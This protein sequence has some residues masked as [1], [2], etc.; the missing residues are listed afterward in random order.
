VKF[1]LKY[2][3]GITKKICMLI[4]SGQRSRFNRLV[5]TGKLDIPFKDNYLNYDLISFSGKR[6]LE[7]QILSISSFVFNVG[8][9]RQWVVYSDGS[10][11]IEERELIQKQFSFAVV[12]E[13]NCNTDLRD[14]K[15]LKD[16][17]ETCHLSKKLYSILGHDYQRQT[18]YADSDIVFYKK[19]FEYFNSEALNK[20][21]WYI[22][23]AG[24]D[25][26]DKVSWK[27]ASLNSGLMILNK[28]FDFSL[29]FHYLDSLKNKYEYFSEQSSFNYSFKKQPSN[30]LNPGLFVVDTTDQFKVRMAYEAEQ[31][32]VR[33]YVNPVRHKM[34]QK[35]WRWH[36]RS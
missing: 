24:S 11:S 21:F 9:P 17:L 13:W 33:H 7:E 30:I 14:N 5:W 16:Y 2:Q 12:R 1:K 27:N 10:H 18:I 25:P 36:L 19:A 3:D 32:A 22:L 34:W 31:V 8:I 35:G 20:D 6:D 4:A 28:S 26:K 15:W 29:V 23:D